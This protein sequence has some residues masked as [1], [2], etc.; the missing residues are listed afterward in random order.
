[1]NSENIYRDSLIR[2]LNIDELR[3][4]FWQT[5]GWMCNNHKDEMDQAIASALL[6]ITKG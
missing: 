5:Y 2:D 1:M 4:L 3:L 6:D